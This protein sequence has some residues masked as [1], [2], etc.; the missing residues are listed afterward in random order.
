MLGQKVSERSYIKLTNFKTIPDETITVIPIW[1]WVI[2]VLHFFTKKKITITTI[3]GEFKMV[4]VFGKSLI[5]KG[6]FK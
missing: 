5:D 2:N 4:N 1:G 6:I 3:H